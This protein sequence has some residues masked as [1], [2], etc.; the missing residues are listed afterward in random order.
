[1]VSDTTRVIGNVVSLIIFSVVVKLLFKPSAC[2]FA[3]YNFATDIVAGGVVPVDGFCHTDCSTILILTMGKV[4][5]LSSV[6]Q[7]SE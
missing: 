4:S 6:I 7:F 1:M 5:L 3:L 2:S